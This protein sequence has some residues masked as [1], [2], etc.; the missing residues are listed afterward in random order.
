MCGPFTGHCH[1]FQIF[2][3][4]LLFPSHRPIGFDL[5]SENCVIAVAR[6]GGI[7]IIAN[8]A[9]YRTTP[10]LVTFAQE[11]RYIGQSAQ[12]QFKRNVAATVTNVKVSRER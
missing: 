12:A 10:A 8:E 6:K 4:K 3:K 2:R 7:D 11:Q 5:G 9:S 1:A